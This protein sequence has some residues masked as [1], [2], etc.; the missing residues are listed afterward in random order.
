MKN[1]INKLYLPKQ[2][3]RV[4]VPPTVELDEPITFKDSA[5]NRLGLHLSEMMEV[6]ET[7]KPNLVSLP[8]QPHGKTGNKKRRNRFEL[9]LSE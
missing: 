4:A 3:G 6:I 9:V 2:M 1:F 7:M 8:Q 5:E